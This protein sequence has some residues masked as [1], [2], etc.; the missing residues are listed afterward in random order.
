M[1]TYLKAKALLM[2]GSVLILTILSTFYVYFG[3]DKLYVHIVCGVYNAGINIPVVLLFGAYNRK[4]ID[5][6]N[7]NVFN[8]QGIGLAQWLISF[9]LIILPCIIWFPIK[10][11]IG[12]TAANVTLLSLGIL[13]LLCR[14]LI[15]NFIAQ[16]YT[17]RRFSMLEGFKQRS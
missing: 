12:L 2:D 17:S 11:F 4:Y 9:P 8:Y 5:L 1:R 14:P 6:S 7:S 15:L 3:W 10:V 13:G 16:L